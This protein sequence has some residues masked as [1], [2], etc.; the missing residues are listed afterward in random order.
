MRS[1]NL[2]GQTVHISSVQLYT[3]FRKLTWLE[4]QKAED[5]EDVRKKYLDELLVADDIYQMAM[6]DA[7]VAEA[8]SKAVNALSKLEISK[9]LESEK[10]KPVE[11]GEEDNS[12][13]QDA[14]NYFNIEDALQ[15]TEKEI[16]TWLKSLKQRITK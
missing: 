1:D 4:K 10:Q 2:L 5:S 13:L 3:I 8:K 11:W 16:V 9:L 6:N 12:F 14:V 15:H 7:M